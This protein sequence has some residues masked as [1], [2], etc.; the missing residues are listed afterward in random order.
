MSEALESACN[1]SVK[2][3]FEEARLT[4]D[5]GALLLREA[6]HRLGITADP[7]SRAEIIRRTRSMP[8][9]QGG[10]TCGC[11]E[12]RERKTRGAFR[13]RGSLCL[14]G[15][16]QLIRVAVMLLAAWNPGS[17]VKTWE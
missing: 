8:H 5:A 11:L 2:F 14:A 13:R 12:R 16:V 4:S 3:R 15:R 1:R 9:G 17:K 10:Y 6:D 7:S